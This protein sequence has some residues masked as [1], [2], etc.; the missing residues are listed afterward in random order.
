MNK[1]WKIRVQPAGRTPYEFKA[2]FV[3]RVSGRDEGTL[4]VRYLYGDGDLAVLLEDLGAGAPEI[5]GLIETLQNEGERGDRGGRDRRGDG[6]PGPRSRARAEK[7]A[8]V[9]ERKKDWVRIAFFILSPIV[10]IVGTAAWALTHGVAWWQPALFFVLYACVGVSVT[11]GY[12]R[13]FAHRTYECHPA[14]QAFYLFFGAMALQNSILELGLRPPPAPPLRGPRLGS[15]QHP[16][17][18]LVGAH[19]VDLLQERGRPEVRRRA[20]PAEE[21][22]RSSPVPILEP[23]RHRRGPRDPDR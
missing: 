22:P 7:R 15:V 17:R 5:F 16:A 8:D 6:G 19:R 14:V 13:L 4:D 18:R 20:G 11:A 2:T 3:G 23:D 21:P 9:N 10:G 12:H 1:D